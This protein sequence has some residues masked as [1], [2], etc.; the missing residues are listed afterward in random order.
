MDF[1]PDYFDREG[2]NSFCSA[3]KYMLDLCSTWSMLSHFSHARTP[4]DPMACGLPGSSVHGD[5][6]S[7]NTGVSCHVLL[8]GIFPTQGSNLCLLQLLLCRQILYH[9]ATREAPF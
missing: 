7:K 9:C 8:Q 6:L 1:F 2:R 4:C 3:S 5:S